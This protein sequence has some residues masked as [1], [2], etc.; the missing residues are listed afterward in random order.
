MQL[1][2][3]RR[4]VEQRQDPLLH[5]G[6]LH[7]V[8]LDDHVLLQD[9]DGVQLLCPLPVGQHHLQADGGQPEHRGTRHGGGGAGAGNVC[10]DLS[11]FF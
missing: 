11:I 6:A 5:H 10:T 8:V 3:E 9:L 4:L 7:V 2:Q 1:R